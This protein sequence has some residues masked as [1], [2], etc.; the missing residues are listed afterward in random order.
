MSCIHQPN[1]RWCAIQKLASWMDPA[2]IA[3]MKGALLM[4]LVILAAAPQ[5]AARAADLYISNRWSPRNAERPK[6]HSTRYIVLH[7]TEGASRGALKK[8]KRSG[9]A[10][11]LVDELGRVYRIVDKNRVA[12]HAG[13]S[14]WAGTR[15]LDRHSLGIEVAGYHHRPIRPAQ[16]KA[17]RELIRQLQS[18]YRVPDHRVLTHSMVAYGTP[19]RY[20]RYRHRGRKRCG[21][22]FA[23]PRLR[24]QLGLRGRPK[25]DPDVRDGRLKV[26]DAE[27]HRF[28][29]PARPATARSGARSADRR[30]AA[31]VPRQRPAK[32]PDELARIAS[33]PSDLTELAVP[34]DPSTGHEPPRPSSI[35]PVP[36]A[37]VGKRTEEGAPTPR[38]LSVERSGRS[39]EALVGARATSPHTIYLFPSGLVRTGRALARSESQR[40]LLGDLPAGTRI[41][42]GHQFGGYVTARRA[43]SDIAGAHWDDPETFYRL[44]SGKLVPGH[45][46]DAARVPRSTLVFPPA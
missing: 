41:L 42:I 6:R 27:L 10:H 11:Y 40:A 44:P 12:Y 38:L 1:D 37:P 9:E 46:I 22:I 31:G 45:R 19:N 8:L 20:H 25:A 7:T 29:Y 30:P 5:P 33:L 2:T 3:A 26:A 43:P 34:K 24:K 28:L 18:L 15:N 23:D 4:V 16:V 21:M 39:A 17:L 32:V 36:P 14:M 35:S 13:T